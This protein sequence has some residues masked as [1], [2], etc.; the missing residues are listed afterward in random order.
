[1][2][3]TLLDRI[4]QAAID[5]TPVGLLPHVIDTI[6]GFAGELNAGQQRAGG[7]NFNANPS[8]TYT[9]QNPS[10]S[11][12]A[13]VVN[14]VADF[15]AAQNGG[16]N[17]AIDKVLQSG[18]GVIKGS[19][20]LAPKVGAAEDF[21]LNGAKRIL[22]QGAT[23]VAPTTTE[24]LIDNA[25]KPVDI[26]PTPTSSLFDN[27]PSNV[28]PENTVTKEVT[29]PAPKSTTELFNPKTGVRKLIDREAIPVKDVLNNLDSQFGVKIAARDKLKADLAGPLQESFNKV[30]KGLT[31]EELNSF[32]EVARGTIPA[33]S[34][35]QAAA[36]KE[37][38]NTADT[39]FSEAQKVGVPD[40]NYR[41]N[42][43]PKYGDLSKMTPAEKQAYS[44]IPRD[45]NMT[46]GSL[47]FSQTPTDNF[48]QIGDPRVV[49]PRYIESVSK[50]IANATHFG[51]TGEQLY[52]LA[53]Q[54]RDPQQA[55]QYV[56]QLLNKNQ[57][58]TL[59]GIKTLKDLETA[60]DIGFTS[61]IKHLT[62]TVA[63][64]LRTDPASVTSSFAR[65]ISN[66]SEAASIAREA[67]V[68]G[69]G[70][71]DLIKQYA[72]GDT[73]KLS[74]KI[75]SWSGMKKFI[76]FNQTM[77][78]N[79][80]Y[81][82]TAKLAE[83]AAN[84][85]ESA[86]RELDRLG[87]SP[88][89]VVN[90]ITKSD[91]FQGARAVGNQIGIIPSTGDVP[92]GYRAPN[93]SAAHLF[94]TY[95]YKETKFLVTQSQRI[96]GEAIQGNFKPLASALTAIGVGAGVGDIINNVQSLLT[97]KK[98]D[99][100]NTIV[101]RVLSDVLTGV[102]LGVVS[103]AEG[104]AYGTP[105]VAGVVGGPIAS[106]AVKAAETVSNI[107]AGL[108]GDNTAAHS[109]ERAV[110]S[111]IPIVGQAAANTLVPNSYV[112]NYVGQNNGLDTT[113]NATYNNMKAIDPVAAEKFKQTNQYV[114]KTG[115][116]GNTSGGIIGSAKKLFGIDQP[117]AFDWSAVPTSKKAKTAYN[118][119]V[120]QAL[121]SGATV[122]DN[123]LNQRFFDGKTYD[124]GNNG[125]KETIMKAA[126]TV[127]NDQYLTDAQKSSILNS[128][129][130]TQDN[131]DY[132]KLASQNETDKI[133]QFMDFANSSQMSHSDLLNILALNKRRVAGQYI[134]TPALVDE[135]YQQ[136][137][138]SKDD[139]A[140]LTAIKYDSVY[141][142]F[143]M[144]KAYT[145]GGMTA[146]QK[147]AYIN[148]V[149]SIF[150]TT[151]KSSAAKKTLS[152]PKAPATQTLSP[153]TK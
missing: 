2:A 153:L 9:P 90:G 30:V 137:M 8:A 33:I 96:A 18:V 109:A 88:D 22:G 40:V 140:L 86:L 38:R 67:G 21:I 34:D 114:D 43:Y 95:G 150:K 16:I 57:G 27:V 134:T 58:A 138:I 29:P 14:P 55:M 116:P 42:Y 36:V 64:V 59:P 110:L 66:P 115:A 144:D 145:G 48:P 91:L 111:Q 141:N 28:S 99:D 104:L 93:E 82:Y 50:D 65:I 130:V 32:P 45:A 89:A 151:K 101:Q 142:K 97:N 1:M 122:P 76:Q 143:F 20:F 56:D 78:T 39:L 108:N 94:G 148:K 68:T 54:T 98:R 10:Q 124:Q 75:L 132:Y 15:T 44:A 13:S 120:D 70:F 41:Q 11:F 103:S 118:T 62:N 123:A 102:P 147:S 7:Q 119:Q 12:G 49:V 23:D 53:Q 46:S 25:K 112:K 129:G 74:D 85:S 63:T 84:G 3:L 77:T 5:A 37:W 152:L 73:G 117:P 60:K 26:P 35:A 79:V 47:K 81:D 149:N 131:L 127:A 72:G 52:Q 135:L 61:T 92:F 51:K 24:T 69:S 136:G 125:D 113:D 19:S 4:K 139:K 87:I 106:D 83:Q 6:K 80:G 146:A 105:G 128:A 121:S 100:A 71:E 133:S 126:V 17:D 31:P 107:G